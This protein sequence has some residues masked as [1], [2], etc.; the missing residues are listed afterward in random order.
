LIKKEWMTEE[1]AVT[2]ADG[3][4][5]LEGFYGSYHFRH[6]DDSGNTYGILRNLEKQNKEITI[7]LG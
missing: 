7:R 2:N 4:I 3:E 5:Q 6:Q 1:T